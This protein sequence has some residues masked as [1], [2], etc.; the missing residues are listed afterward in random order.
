M[1]YHRR[2]RDSIDYDVKNGR[3]AGDKSKFVANAK[4]KNKGKLVSAATLMSPPMP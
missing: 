1:S 2:H 4:N 3:T